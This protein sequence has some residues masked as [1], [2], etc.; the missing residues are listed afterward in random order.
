MSSK[1]PLFALHDADLLLALK[2]EPDAARP[3]VF[4]RFLSRRRYLDTSDSFAFTFLFAA[5]RP[6][7]PDLRFLGAGLRSCLSDHAQVSHARTGP[8]WFCSAQIE[9][10]R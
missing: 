2:R 5:G 1:G 7:F 6:P 3:G 10:E 4:E 9:T 8:L